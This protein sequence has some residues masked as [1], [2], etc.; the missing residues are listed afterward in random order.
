CRPS[1]PCPTS[2]SAKDR[3]SDLLAPPR[4]A[5]HVALTETAVGLALADL[6]EPKARTVTLALAEPRRLCARD[7][8]WRAIGV[9]RVR[10]VVDATAGLG[11]DSVA[12]AALGLDVVAI[13]R[14][15][16]LVALWEDAAR[17]GR[18][19]RGLRFVAGDAVEI[20]RQ[21]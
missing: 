6:D 4:S 17:R 5:V 20:L 10:S 12:L 16:L 1:S 11:R 13:E 2:T 21:L 3:R 14:A 19:P 8:L 7:G 18:L 9:G 15:P